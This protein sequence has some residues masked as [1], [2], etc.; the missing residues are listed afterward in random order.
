M[1]SN[2]TESGLHRFI[3]HITKEH[4]NEKKAPAWNGKIE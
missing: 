2:I 3:V 1:K 4:F